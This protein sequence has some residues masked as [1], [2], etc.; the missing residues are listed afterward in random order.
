MTEVDA[1]DSWQGALLHVALN[2]D[3]DHSIDRT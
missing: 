1:Y 3:R 2:H